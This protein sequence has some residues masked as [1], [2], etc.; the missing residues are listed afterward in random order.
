MGDVVIY[1]LF[2]DVPLIPQTIPP[3]VF[4]YRLTETLL[5]LL[6]DVIPRAP[7]MTLPEGNV[8]AVRG[9]VYPALNPGSEVKFY[10][11][12]CTTRRVAHLPCSYL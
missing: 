11:P 2:R 6:H 4:N 1:E 9:R 7:I 3:D 5:M 10:R 8:S 12:V